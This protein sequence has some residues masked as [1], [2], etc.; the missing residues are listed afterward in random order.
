VRD[1]RS[2]GWRK[3]TDEA[4]ESPVRFLEHS[5]L[6]GVAEALRSQS[7]GSQ[8]VLEVYSPSILKLVRQPVS[9]TPHI[10]GATPRFSWVAGAGI[11][12]SIWSS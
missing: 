3:V 9:C 7:R 8:R 12:L 6:E 1:G 10:L 11:D 5:P 4:R 2:H